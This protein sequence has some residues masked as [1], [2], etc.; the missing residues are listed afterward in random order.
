MDGQEVVFQAV[1]NPATGESVGETSQFTA[2]VKGLS[3]ED[4]FS[5]RIGEIVVHRQTFKNIEFD[6][7]EGKH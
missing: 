4:Q 1:A 5:V 2:S 3:K 6:Y 7:P